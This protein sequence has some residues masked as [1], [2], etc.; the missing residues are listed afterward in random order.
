[1]PRFTNLPKPEICSVSAR[2][3]YTTRVPPGTGRKLSRERR[4]NEAAGV[5][6]DVLTYPT[7]QERHMVMGGTPTLRDESGLLSPRAVVSAGFRS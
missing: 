5:S 3:E 1:M 2:L 4:S 7:P 6:L